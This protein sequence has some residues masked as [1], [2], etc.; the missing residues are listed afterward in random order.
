MRWRYVLLL[1]RSVLSLCAIFLAGVSQTRASVFII[2][3]NQTQ[4]TISGKIAGYIF[5]AQGGGSLTAAYLGNLN[6]TVSGW[7]I[8]FTG[9]ISRALTAIPNGVWRPASGGAAGSAPAGLRNAGRHVPARV[10][11]RRAIWF[12]T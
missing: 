10:M 5:T 12:W 11:P 4:I 6:A 2:D 1:R 3:S 8:Q 7:T 9:L